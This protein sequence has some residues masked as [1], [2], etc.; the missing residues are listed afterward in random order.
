MEVKDRINAVIDFSGKKPATFATHIGC[1]TSQAIYEL[2]KG[3]TKNIS[4]DIRKKILAKYPQINPTWLVTGEGDMLITEKEVVEPK[5]VTHGDKSPAV[6]GDNA[7]V[8]NGDGSSIDEK[9]NAEIAVLK[10]RI[11][12]LEAQLA[13]K[14]ETIEILKGNKA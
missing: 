7:V 2:Q 5:V 13:A 4:E 10:E 8:V 6:M 3:R 12:G 11:R 9:L 1:K 14:N